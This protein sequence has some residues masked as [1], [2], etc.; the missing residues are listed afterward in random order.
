MDTAYTVARWT[1]MLMLIT[2]AGLSLL[3]LLTVA[4]IAFTPGT[5]GIVQ[6]INDFLAA[7]LPLLAAT[8]NDVESRIDVDPGVRLMMVWVIGVIG[9][10]GASCILRALVGSGIALLGF[11]QRRD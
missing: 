5:V 8:N 7:E 11:V 10:I 6:P 1:G 4:Q 3:V 2:A 9:L